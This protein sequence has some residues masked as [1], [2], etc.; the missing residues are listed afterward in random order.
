MTHKISLKVENLESPVEFEVNDD[1]LK[2]F[3]KFCQEKHPE[4]NWKLIFD[5]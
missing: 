3:A 5:S 2:Q 4:K 1:T